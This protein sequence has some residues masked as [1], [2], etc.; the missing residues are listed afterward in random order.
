MII[1]DYIYTRGNHW[2]KELIDRY[3]NENI[4]VT[5]A[6]EYNYAR[7]Y[8]QTPLYYL[9]IDDVPLDL[10]PH[11]QWGY[12]QREQLSNK[13]F[14]DVAEQANKLDEVNESYTQVKGYF[15]RV[16]QIDRRLRLLRNSEEYLNT[17]IQNAKELAEN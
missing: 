3:R 16:D 17:A 4:Y 14:Y 1:E 12:M 13:K 9:L 2:F 7:L 8:L 5:Y 11:N 10:F 6:P 15:G